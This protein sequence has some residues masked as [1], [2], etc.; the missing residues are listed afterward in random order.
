M[1]NL[2][3]ENPK[4]DLHAVV[5]KMA[6]IE[7]DHAK[8][9]NLGVSY[10]MGKP[11]LAASLKTTIPRAVNLL[12]RFHE[13][14]PYLLSLDNICKK[15]MKIKGHIKTI[16]GRRLRNESKFEYKALNKLI[17]GSA[18]D[19]TYACMVAAYRAG[20]T[21]LFPIHDELTLSGTL[22]EAQILQNIMQNTVKLEVPSVSEILGGE[23]W[24]EVVALTKK[25]TIL[26]VETHLNEGEEMCLTDSISFYGIS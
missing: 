16:G 1:V 14:V 18:A 20:I 17:Q 6:G 8:T 15:S 26:P 5:A 3:K 12:N 7:R 10:G 25:D 13:A 22:E 2:Y 24:G 4:F 9:I 19:Q 23:S 21:I 11:K